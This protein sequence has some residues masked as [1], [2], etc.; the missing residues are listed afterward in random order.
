MGMNGFYT[1]SDHS[2]KQRSA[3]IFKDRA[4]RPELV[5]QFLVGSATGNVVDLIFYLK[6]AKR[7]LYSSEL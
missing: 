7:M 2:N 6:R 3:F 5:R 1:T 4:D